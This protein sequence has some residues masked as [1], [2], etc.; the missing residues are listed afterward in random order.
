M[1]NSPKLPYFNFEIFTQY[2]TVV[3]TIKY[4]LPRGCWLGRNVTTDVKQ[5]RKFLCRLRSDSKVFEFR[6]RV[7]FFVALFV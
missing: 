7:L 4:P 2:C 1:T 6:R 5:R 3:K